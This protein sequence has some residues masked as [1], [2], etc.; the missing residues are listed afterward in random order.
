MNTATNSMG[1]L[2]SLHNSR[3]RRIL[4]SI[5]PYLFTPPQTV[6]CLVQQTI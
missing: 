3:M 5:A 4:L 1:V 6:Y 2:R